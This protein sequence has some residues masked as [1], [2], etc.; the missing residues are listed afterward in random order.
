M[1]SIFK[2]HSI[3]R[4]AA[5]VYPHLCLLLSSR[6]MGGQKHRRGVF[7]NSGFI[8]Y[9]D[10]VNQRYFI[11]NIPEKRKKNLAKNTINVASG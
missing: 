9:P 1:K 11:G 6:R 2:N 5:P 7:G 10:A 4:H 3:F 8:H